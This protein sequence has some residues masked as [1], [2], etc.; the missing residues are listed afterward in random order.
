MEG[1][2]SFPSRH[3]EVSKVFSPI[4]RAG[5]QLLRRA[6]IFTSCGQLYHCARNRSRFGYSD[7]GLEDRAQFSCAHRLGEAAAAPEPSP[8]RKSTKSGA[9]L[10]LWRSAFPFRIGQR[11]ERRLGSSPAH[12]AEVRTI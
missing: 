7:S 5:F 9:V 4:P 8:G 6:E 3:A 12:F 11:N 1:R 10:L 2:R